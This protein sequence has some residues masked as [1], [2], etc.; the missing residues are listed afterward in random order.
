MSSKDL[1]L[2][3]FLCNTLNQNLSYSLS[4][5]SSEKSFFDLQFI[6]E[7]SKPCVPR[8]LIILT[9]KVTICFRGVSRPSSVACLV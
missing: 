6:Y 9:N 3:I 5:R 8:L 7:R 4:F 2:V 1:Q